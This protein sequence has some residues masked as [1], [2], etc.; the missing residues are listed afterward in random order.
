MI[1]ATNVKIV[2]CGGVGSWI[3]YFLALASKDSH[4]PSINNLTLIDDDMLEDNNLTRLPT[5]HTSGRKK[6]ITYL[7]NTIYDTKPMFTINTIGSALSSDNIGV[8]LNDATHVFCATD[9]VDIQRLVRTYCRDNEIEYQ[10]AGY[11]GDWITITRG[12]PITFD[13][14][15]EKQEGTDYR[16]KPKVYQ[17]ALAGLLAVYSMFEKEISISASMSTLTAYSSSLIPKTIL[18]KLEDNIRD[19]ILDSDRYHSS[20]DCSH[21]DCWNYEDAVEQFI[22]SIDENDIPQNI[23]RIVD[24]YIE[25]MNKDDVPQNLI[26][27]IIEDFKDSMTRDDIPDELMEELKSDLEALEA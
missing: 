24:N 6:K 8:L 20:D 4:F 25:Q 10:R 15:Q 5:A 18:S 12:I 26:D 27:D 9:T 7:S 19:N 11:D 3:A 1:K 16:N 21:D 22:D 13:P 14:Q 2:G 17:A 23:Q